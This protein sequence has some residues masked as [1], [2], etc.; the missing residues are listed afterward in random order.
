MTTNGRGQEQRRRKTKRETGGER[1]G[2]M[3]DPENAAFCEKRAGEVG[4][5]RV[6][7]WRTET[8]PFTTTTK[9]TM[10]VPPQSSGEEEA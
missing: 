1:E 7:G 9:R 10:M 2:Q 4:E 5:G 6:Q 8:S 3:T